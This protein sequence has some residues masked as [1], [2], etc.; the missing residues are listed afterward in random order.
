MKCHSWTNNTNIVVKIPIT[1]SLN[2]SIWFYGWL[3]EYK[4]KHILISINQYG[5]DAPHHQLTWSWGNPRAVFPVRPILQAGQPVLLLP[6]G[7]N[8]P[9]FTLPSHPWLC[10]DESLQRHGTNTER[11]CNLKQ[12]QSLIMQANNHGSATLMLR[13]SSMT[14]LSF[15]WGSLGS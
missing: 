9:R 11:K 12:M 4:K 2:V 14:C 15:L 5:H 3:Y 13:Q 6:R 10:T 8:P 1:Q 7:Y